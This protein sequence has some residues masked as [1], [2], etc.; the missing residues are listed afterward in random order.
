[1]IDRT[2]LRARLKYALLII[3]VVIL[4]LTSRKIPLLPLFL[5]DIL[6]ACMMFLLI[7]FIFI[8]KSLVWVSIISLLICFSVEISQLY[9]ATWIDNIRNTGL[10]ALALGHGFLWTDLLAYTAGIVICSAFEMV[11]SKQKQSTSVGYKN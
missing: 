3:F 5:G 1:M 4:G 6:W 2:I 8:Y 11:C 9:H 10:G 7:K